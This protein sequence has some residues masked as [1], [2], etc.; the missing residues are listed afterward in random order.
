MRADGATLPG[1]D[2]V[3]DYVVV[4][5]GAAGATAARALAATGRSVCVLEEG[6]AVDT[7]DFHDRTWDSF[8]TLFRDA[9][10]Q[11]ARG[12]AFIPVIQGR[13]LGGST[14]INSA[15]VWRLPDDILAEWAAK[16]YADALPGKELHRIWDDIEKD[17]SVAPA[18]RAVWG[19]NNRLMHEGA[20]KLGVGAAAI[21]RYAKDCRGSARCLTGCPHGAKQSMLV[22]YLPDA[23]AAGATLLSG[24]EAR[25]VIIDGGRAVAVEGRLAGPGKRTFRAAARRAVIVAASAIQTPQLLARSG[26]RSIHLGAHFMAHP[27]TPLAGVWEK[28]VDMWFGATQG[29]DADHHRREGR[30]K[31]ETIA[32]PP[33]IVFARM[34]GA[35][36]RLQENLLKAR[37]MAVW[38][39]QMR[40]WAE[41]TVR[42]SPFGADIRY[43]LTRR[44]MMQ[45]RRGLRF[46]A[47]LMFAAGA[48]ELSLNIHGLPETLMPGEEWKLEHGPDDPRAYSWIVSHLFGTAR[49]AKHASQGVVGEDFAVFGV[50]NLVVADSSVFPSNIGVNPQ[51]TIMAAARLCAERLADR[52][53]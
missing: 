26:V 11:V 16:G 19:E 18:P 32:L 1:F 24:A 33:E 15:I 4:G 14:V 23:E 39:V 10:S 7:K 51:H 25:R 38:A 41:G 42:E 45:V 44:D 43:D 46:T 49:M 53:N 28:P 31:I 34:N 29:Y 9:N 27:G 35:G 37:H 52:R 30:F 3:F 21:R 48:R 17:L 47:E 5:S 36:R 13:C 2:E 50:P 12:R 40:A 20:E 22:S 8:R 6:P